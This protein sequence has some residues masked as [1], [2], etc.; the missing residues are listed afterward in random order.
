MT[1]PSLNPNDLI[2]FHFVVS[3][4][5]IK[6]AA[7]K[8]CLAQPTVS[9]HIK[10]LERSVGTKLFESKKGSLRLTQTGKDLA[11]YASQIYHDMASVEQFM[12]FLR[13]P[14]LRAGVAF[15]FAVALRSVVPQFE[16]PNQKEV[17]LSMKNGGSFD[18]I[19]D[20][21]NSELDVGIVVGMDYGKAELKSIP[22]SNHEKMVV[23]ASPFDPIFEK[24]KVELADLSGRKF[25]LPARTSASHQI[26]FKKL[27]AEGLK[28]QS[29]QFETV[30]NTEWS[31]Y[32]VE[33]GEALDFLHISSV[34]ERLSQGRLAVVP[35][36]V[37]FW[38]GAEAIVRKDTFITK[39][40]DAFISS[41]KRT[42]KS[43]H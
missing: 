23:V 38:V 20:V 40:I 39:A 16:Q 33:I 15:T 24:D 11:K 7:E 14:V 6:L 25:I 35:V 43:K 32:L 34:E 27:E 13:Q 26:F 22:V 28:V 42:F 31:R 18:I 30:N 3:E 8:L 41:V 10:T 17:R 21:L 12:D 5:S 9:Y 2:V 36:P 29:S 19:Q 37:D 4:R 1:I